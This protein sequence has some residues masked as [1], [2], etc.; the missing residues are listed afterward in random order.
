MNP[1]PFDKN[2]RI[3]L[4][5]PLSLIV[6]L[7]LVIVSQQASKYPFAAPDA[8]GGTSTAAIRRVEIKHSRKATAAE[9]RR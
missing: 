8:S 5:D 3:I 1:R 4:A 6:W 2:R 7:F 9:D